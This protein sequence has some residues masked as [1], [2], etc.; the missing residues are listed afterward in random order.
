MI[1]EQI[2]TYNMEFL[3]DDTRLWCWIVYQEGQAVNQRSNSVKIDA[4]RK[5]TSYQINENRFYVSNIV[6]NFGKDT[7]GIHH[8]CFD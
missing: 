3:Q 7:L 6:D 5:F 1:E 4:L 8:N 2:R